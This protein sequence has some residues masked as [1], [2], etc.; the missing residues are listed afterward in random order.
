MP[1][2][3]LVFKKQNG[4]LRA[5][6]GLIALGL[7]VYI[8]VPQL[9]EFKNSTHLLGDASL[10]KVLL[11]IVMSLGAHMLAAAKYNALALRPLRY[12][13]T[14][15]VQ[16][17]GLLTNRLLPAGIG[18]IGINYLYLRRERHTVSE[19]TAVLTMNNLLGL[20]GHGLL[21][22][23]LMM[24]VNAPNVTLP[25][26]GILVIMVIV[27]AFVAVIAIVWRKWWH[28]TVGL[29]SVIKDVVRYRSRPAA[30]LMTIM[31]SVGI[32]AFYAACLWYS[33]QA[34]HFPISFM[35]ALIV[36]TVGIA[37]S[38]V[39]PTPGGLVGVEAAL[40]AGLVAYKVN[41]ADALAIALLYRLI[42]YWLALIMGLVAL[43][44]IERKNIV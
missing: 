23:A 8:V 28:I 3:K 11:A 26:L 22:G 6:I 39:T 18:G 4:S 1:S 13:R 20:V 37:A 35:T 16:L 40:V 14:L 10:A 7:L 29:A 43:F 25:S 42:T 32:A 5:V 17:A 44:W 38:T 15:L 41:T 2:S 12:G 34:L 27:M 30:V 31:Y 36:L 9:H 24:F 33:A 21:V 19:T